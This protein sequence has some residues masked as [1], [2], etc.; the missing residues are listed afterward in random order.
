M[1]DISRAYPRS[2]QTTLVFQVSEV[3]RFS[4]I[5]RKD[6]LNSLEMLLTPKHQSGKSVEGKITW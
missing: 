6:E 3:F 4:F 1:A 5:V 2:T